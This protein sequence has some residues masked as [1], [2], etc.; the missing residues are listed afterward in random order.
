VARALI[1]E[2]EVLIAMLLEDMLIDLRHDVVAIATT[3]MEAIERASNLS[4]DFAILDVNMAGAR[5]DPVAA[6]LH[7][8]EIPFAFA[9]GYG[10]RGLLGQW[11]EAPLLAK[12]FLLSE[13]REATEKLLSGAK[14][15]ADID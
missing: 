12:P 1:V 4:I 2:D 10:R 15:H 13:L 3:V 14:P 6:V 7:A 8:R 11:S 9:T 5:S